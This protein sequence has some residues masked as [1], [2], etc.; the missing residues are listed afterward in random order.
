M[1]VGRALLPEKMPS[2]GGLDTTAVSK[3]KQPT[4]RCIYTASYD[5]Q[6]AIQRC[7]VPPSCGIEMAGC[8]QLEAAGQ[9][10]MSNFE[11]R[12]NSWPQ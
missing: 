7:R 11:A 8:R 9:Q 4:K 5:L 3:Q 1:S 10:V 2:A 6:A 12:D